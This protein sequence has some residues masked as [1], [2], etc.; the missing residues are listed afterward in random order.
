MMR[1]HRNGETADRDSATAQHREPR[2]DSPGSSLARI[3]S[4]RFTL[5]C[6]GSPSWLLCTVLSVLVSGGYC[7]PWGTLLSCCPC[8]QCSLS[9]SLGNLLPPCSGSSSLLTLP[10]YC[11]PL[12]EPTDAYS[13]LGLY[14]HS[15]L[16][17]SFPS[18]L[19]SPCVLSGFCVLL[20]MGTFLLSC[21]GSTLFACCLVCFVYCVGVVVSLLEV[22]E[23]RVAA[24]YDSVSCWVL[25]FLWCAC[26]VMCVG[27]VYCWY[28][29]SL[30]SGVVPWLLPGVSASFLASLR[31]SSRVSFLSLLSSPM[32][33][34]LWAGRKVLA[35]FG[36]AG[37]C[38][39]DCAGVYAGLDWKSR[40]RARVFAFGCWS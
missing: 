37:V 5:D 39:L 8:S 22:V 4:L 34:G 31:F 2:T 6:S 14:Y 3:I 26:L 29:L 23:C 21:L 25:V 10:V 16:L 40:S 17:S 15:L 32:A 35:I 13:L 33:D 18:F 12:G 36:C 1:E 27:E 20:L 28:Y 24:L 30:L 9:C 19:S 38:A 11:S 7:S